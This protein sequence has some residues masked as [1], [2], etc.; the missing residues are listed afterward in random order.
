MLATAPPRGAEITEHQHGHEHAVT[1]KEW[2]HYWRDSAAKRRG[3]YALIAAFYRRFLIA[4]SVRHFFHRY[5]ADEPGRI[6]VH[7]GCGSGES[8]RDIGFKKATFVLMDI[9]PEALRIARGKTTLPSPYLV[10]GDIFHPPFRT[11]SIDG[12][13]NLGV[14]EHFEEPQVTEIFGA[15]ARIVK[16]RAPMLV[17][18]PPRYGLSV[19]ALTSFL[20]V[21]NRVLRL[22]LQLYPDEVSR[23]ASR[24]WA[25]RLLA[26]AGLVIEKAH[27][28]IRDLFTYV[29]LVATKRLSSRDGME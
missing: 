11:G 26:P 23:Y 15:L 18:W 8:D 3:P 1:S 14:M 5:F 17:F 29:V 27:F 24:G 4:G 20:F 25:T 9:S 21:T 2:D 22:N 13:W 28:G 6:Y 10:C 16:P 12:I 19:I 7:A